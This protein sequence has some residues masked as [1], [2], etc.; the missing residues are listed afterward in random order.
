M[1][2]QIFCFR[3][4]GVAFGSLAARIGG[5]LA[6]TIGTLSEDVDER[7]PPILFGC[8]AFIAAFLTTFLPETAGLPLPKDLDEIKA[9]E[10]EDSRNGTWMRLRHIIKERP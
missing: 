1:S 8:T 5:I 4:A 2:C 10:A 6:T 7:L 3:N 9:R